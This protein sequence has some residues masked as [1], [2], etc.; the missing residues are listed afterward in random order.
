MNFRHEHLVPEFLGEVPKI[1]LRKENKK[2]FVNRA[3]TDW[4]KNSY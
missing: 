4:F 3:F 2:L 1:K